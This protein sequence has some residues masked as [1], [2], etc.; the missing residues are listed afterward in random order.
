MQTPGEMRSSTSPRF[1][2]FAIFQKTRFCKSISLQRHA[3][4]DISP[5][6]RENGWIL[7]ALFQNQIGRSM[8]TVTYSCRIRAQSTLVEKSCGDAGTPLEAHR[9]PADAP[10]GTP[11]SERKARRKGR[12]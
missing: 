10:Q 8:A 2:Y 7:K 12:I 1:R 5:R 11:I 6:R 3:L 4:C 9:A